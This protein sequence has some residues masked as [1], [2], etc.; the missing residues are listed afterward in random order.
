MSRVRI[1][2]EQALAA[3]VEDRPLRATLRHQGTRPVYEIVGEVGVFLVSAEDGTVLSPLSE[4][5][6]RETVLAEWK[7]AGPL[8][9]MELLEKAPAEAGGE[10]GGPIWAAR[11]EG[12]GRPVLYVRANTGV[13]GPVRTD[14]WRTYDL[15]W[16][17]H[18]MDYRTRENFNHPLIIAAAVLALSLTLFGLTLVVHRFTRRSGPVKESAAGSA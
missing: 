3:V 1:S 8:A 4:E 11:F 10:A 12:A 13:V 2:L 15:L 16:S 14:L 7:G 17:L 18:I 9:A 6:A 5:L